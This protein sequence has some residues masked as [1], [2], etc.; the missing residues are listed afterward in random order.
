MGT[1]EQICL[2]LKNQEI[3]KWG[4]LKQMYPNHSKHDILYFSIIS[5][6]SKNQLKKTK[7]WQALKDCYPDDTDWSVIRKCLQQAEQS[8]TQ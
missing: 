6:L 3:E 2:S 7:T 1:I 4:K 8:L 5:L